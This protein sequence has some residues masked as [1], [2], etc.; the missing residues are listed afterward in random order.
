VIEIEIE[1]KPNVDSSV[2]IVYDPVEN[3]GK[4]GKVAGI[5]VGSFVAVMLVFALIFNLKMRKQKGKIA[6]LDLDDKP[7]DT[8]AAI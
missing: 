1:T 4:A 7:M 6:D 5:L 8:E 2:M 3:K